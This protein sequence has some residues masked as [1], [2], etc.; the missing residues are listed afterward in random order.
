MFNKLFKNSFAK[1]TN[2]DVVLGVE[3]LK[4]Y[5]GMEIC[6]CHPMKDAVCVKVNTNRGTEKRKFERF[7]RENW[8]G[9]VEVCGDGCL[10]VSK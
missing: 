1:V 5:E 6:H 4:E 3:T 9:T 7:V 2:E 8:H 10:R